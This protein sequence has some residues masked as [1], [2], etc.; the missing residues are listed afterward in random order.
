VFAQKLDKFY[1]LLGVLFFTQFGQAFAFSAPTG[2]SVSAGGGEPDD[3]QGMRV[4]AQ[5]DWGRRVAS[6]HYIDFRGYWDASFAVWLSEGNSDNEH[7]ALAAIAF[8]PMFR[9]QG[10]EQLSKT[11]SPYFQASVGLAVLSRSDLGRRDLGK[12]WQFQDF[13]GGGLQFG[14]NL[15]WDIGVHYLHYSNAGFNPPNQGIDV[16]VLLMLQT[17]F[18]LQAG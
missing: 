11:Y 14:K 5:W 2:Y 4:A 8:A 17:H 18:S 6:Q 1:L 3:L 16:K 12:H 10:T 13:L 15:M 9:F 7:R